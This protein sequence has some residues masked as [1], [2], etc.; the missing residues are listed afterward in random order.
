MKRWRQ[1]FTFVYGVAFFIGITFLMAGAILL[2]VTVYLFVT[3][4]DGTMA[5]WDPT[6]KLVVKGPYC[7]QTFLNR[8]TKD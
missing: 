7:Y 6:Q 5:P 1:P 2:V 4:G 3:V 8:N